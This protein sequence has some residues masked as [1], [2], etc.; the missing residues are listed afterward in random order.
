M[1]HTSQSPWDRQEQINQTAD[2]LRIDVRWAASETG[3]MPAEL[4]I[5]SPTGSVAPRCRPAG[6]SARA[7]Q[8]NS[9]NNLDPL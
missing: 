5:T 2:L 9:K 7:Y 8:K 4:F 3:F 6:S 1:P